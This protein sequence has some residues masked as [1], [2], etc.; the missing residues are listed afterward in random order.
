M[1]LYVV[2]GISRSSV[3]QCVFKEIVLISFTISFDLSYFVSVNIQ[4]VFYSFVFSLSM[5]IIIYLLLSIFRLFGK[6]YAISLI[7]KI[8]KRDVI[9]DPGVIHRLHQIIV[10]SDYHMF[11]IAFWYEITAY[12]VVGYPLIP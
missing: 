9:W 11:H 8:N 12:T 7:Y 4:I 6:A 5:Y 3:H 2:C 1:Y 10:M